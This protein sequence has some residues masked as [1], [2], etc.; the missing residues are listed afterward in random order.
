[1]AL[2][3]S[4][5]VIVVFAVISIYSLFVLYFIMFSFIASDLYT[6]RQILPFGQAE[7]EH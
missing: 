6:I 1:M 7:V 2:L 3:C 5:N 4:Q